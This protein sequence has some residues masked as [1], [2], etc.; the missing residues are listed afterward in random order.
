MEWYVVMIAASSWSRMA[1]AISP[2]LLVAAL[3]ILL[4]VF[5]FEP[6]LGQGFDEQ[7][8]S[9]YVDELG[10]TGPQSASYPEIVRRYLKQQ[11]DYPI[12]LLPPTRV[13]FILAAAA[14]RGCFGGPAIESVRAISC[15]ASIL[16]L[17]LSCAFAWRL[18]G[19]AFAL[20]ILALM[21]VAPTQIYMA[22]RA[23]IDGFFALI[24]LLTLWSLWEVLQQARPT[25][26]GLG[27][28]GVG[29]VLLILTKENAAFVYVAILGLLVMNRWFGLGHV[30][31]SL[32]ATTLVA[33]VVGVGLL[34]LFAG[35]IEPLITVFSLN[36]AKSIQTPYAITTGDGPWFRYLS[37]LLL[38]SPAVVLFAIGGAFVLERRD[39]PG[40][41][42]LGFVVF[43]Y[44]VMCNLRYGM[45]LRYANMWDFPLRYL[46]LV[47]VFTW[48]HSIHGNG[49]RR[50]L[51]VGIVT[52]LAIFELANYL[53]IFVAHDVYDPIPARLLQALDILKS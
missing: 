20:A 31:K 4:R 12:A 9:A 19:P 48:A 39:K 33:P 47:P 8:Y 50:L 3:G 30:S 26:L 36:A 18:R 42:L 23:L 15:A 11:T 51:V 21:A 28:Y 29:L 25:R 49:K 34:A 46:A 53:R 24:T 52:L 32:L 38:V 43:S 6:V 1:L 44:V 22:H 17:L 41:F 7:I 27:L 2:F 10:A 13:S 40:W 16:V 45:N 5:C 14:W 35:G 37:D